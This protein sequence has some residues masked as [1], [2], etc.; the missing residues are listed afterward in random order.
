MASF[1]K[2]DKVKIFKSDSLK[3]FGWGSDQEEWNGHCAEIL[4]P[5]VSIF[6]GGLGWIKVQLDDGD[7]HYFPLKCLEHA[8]KQF[9]IKDE[10]LQPWERF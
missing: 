5:E 1:K 6:H 2:G 9:T 7:W 4:A 8:D 10:P 3:I